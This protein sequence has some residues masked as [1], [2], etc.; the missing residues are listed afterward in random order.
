MA[1]D[2][3]A[4]SLG[5]AKRR[6]LAN[7]A[8]V[9]LRSPTKV[10]IG[11]F[12]LAVALSRSFNFFGP[13]FRINPC[14]LAAVEEF[15]PLHSGWFQTDMQLC[16]AQL[17]LSQRGQNLFNAVL[18]LGRPARQGLILLLK[19]LSDASGW[20]DTRGPVGALYGS[21]SRGIQK[22]L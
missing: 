1:T 19:S 6:L 14:A 16:A 5:N 2:G 17:V 20:G 10:E 13:S 21:A 11:C 8:Y 7:K 18:G 15:A 12:N 9:V 3:F 4:S 22:P